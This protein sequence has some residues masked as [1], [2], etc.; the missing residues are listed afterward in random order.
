[1]TFSFFQKELLHCRHT[2]YVLFIVAVLRV[3]MVGVRACLL[4]QFLTSTKTG[5]AGS[6][7]SLLCSD[8]SGF[9]AVVF[10]AVCLDS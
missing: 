3:F 4:V 1:M 5:I 2:L 7:M 9:V 8:I 10:V 6:I